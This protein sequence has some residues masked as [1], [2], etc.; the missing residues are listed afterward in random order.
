MGGKRNERIKKMVQQYR[1]VTEHADQTGHSL[2][3]LVADKPPVAN[4]IAIYSDI[5]E[6]CLPAIATRQDEPL[7]QFGITAAES[8]PVPLS[9]NL[10]ARTVPI[11]D[12]SFS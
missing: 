4:P 1:R 6:T 11:F 5:Y 2:L 9:M 10:R 7:P 12:C 3:Y 8:P